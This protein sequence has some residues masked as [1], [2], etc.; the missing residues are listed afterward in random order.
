MPTDEA[1][2]ILDRRAQLRTSARRLHGQGR[3]RPHELLEAAAAWCREHEVEWDH[4]GRGAILQDFEAK[5]ADLLG[6]E[7]ARFMPSG[8]MAQQIA[9]RIWADRAGSSHVG[10]HPTA[11]VELHEERGYAH[12]HGLRVSLVGPERT[13]LLAEHLRGL[14]E[15]IAA[16]L[17]ELPIREAG[18]QLPTWDELEQLKFAAAELSVPLHLDGARLWECGPAYGRAL[19]EITRGFASCYVS[20]Y[21]GIGALP[22]SMLLGAKDFV[23]QAAVWQKRHGGNLFSLAPN[24][25]TAAMRLDERLARMPLWLERARSMAATLNAIDGVRTLPDVPHT[26]LFHLYLDLDA[27]RALAARDAVAEQCGIWL[28][29][30]IEPADRPGTSRFEL[31]VGDAAMALSDEEVGEAFAMLLQRD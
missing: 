15:P 20:F 9:L 23:D 3:T 28:Y 22:G 8:T 11:H 17:V 4:Y 14:S 6:F 1:Q 25:A 2:G 30:S 31:Y 13:P 27:E 26:N 7:A 10:M 19:S 12:L 21:K 29:E 18:G 5:V 24:A 16:L